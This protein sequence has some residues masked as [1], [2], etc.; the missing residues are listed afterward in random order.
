[1]CVFLLGPKERVRAWVH[2]PFATLR[3]VEGQRPRKALTEG[4]K[5][6]WRRRILP[7]DFSELL[8]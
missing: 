6:G 2:Q 1:M 5:V 4:E 7:V 8:L 3:R